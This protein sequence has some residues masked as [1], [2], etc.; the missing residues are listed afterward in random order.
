MKTKNKNKK[1]TTTTYSSYTYRSPKFE[2]ALARQ[3]SDAGFDVWY[4]V[5]KLPYIKPSQKSWYLPDFILPNG[6]IIEA[7]GWLDCRER[8]KLKNI[9]ASHPN[10]DI[11]IIFQRPQNKITKYSKTTYA[12]W[13]TQ[14][15]FIWA[16]RWVPESWF[17]ETLGEDQIRALDVLK[18]KEDFHG[19]LPAC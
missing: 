10:L 1:A 15:G 16:D 14:H 6:I 17:Y 4:E 19:Q 12:K 3:I 9:R 7:K 18:F 8:T 2:G 13:A 5:A 11:R